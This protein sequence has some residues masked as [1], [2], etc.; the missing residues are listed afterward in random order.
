M[1]KLLF[2]ALMAAALFSA[3][4]RDARAEIAERPERAGG[5]YFAY[6]VD[7]IN[8]PATTPKGYE[9]FYITHYG[10]HG[11]RFLI[12]DHDYT[13]VM[14]VLEKA[15]KANALTPRGK[16]LKAQM[17]SVWEEAAERGGELSPLGARQHHGIGYRMASHYPQVFEG[18]ADVTAVSTQVMRCAHS[19]FNFING[20]KDV[21]P[22]L[23]IPMESA[24]RQMKYLAY[25]SPESQAINNDKGPYYQ[26]YKRFKNSK[27]NPERLISTI[28]SDPEYV[29]IWVDQKGFMDNLYWVAVDLQNLETPVNLLP[30]FTTDELFDLWSYANFSFFARASSYPRANG[31]HVQNARN[32]VA[33]MVENADAYIADGR[34]GAT[35]RFGHDSNIIPLLGLLRAEGCFSDSDV[36]ED[37]S[38]DYAD[39]FVS[40]M[41]TNLQ[42]VF[43]RPA[44]GKNGDILVR[45]LHNERLSS[46]PIPDAGEKGLYRWEDL[47]KYLL[48]L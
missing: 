12:N 5:V 25:Q 34:H 22:K 6:P 26:D 36:P 31:L 38:K 29:K 11:S 15:E 3:E 41:G 23:E 46:L 7:L 19:M 14:E 32:L 10:R 37:V 48:S 2:F 8:D 24:K 30:L 28:F 4:A 43:F 35:L 21:N 17:D 1:K 9:P 27:I 44:K 13:R 16:Q 20:L 45:M 33:N 40:P 39:Y 47:R 18:D 42:F